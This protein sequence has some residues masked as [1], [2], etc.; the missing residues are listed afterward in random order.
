MKKIVFVGVL[1][2][3]VSVSALDKLTI[4]NRAASGEKILASKQNENMDS[5]AS[6]MNKIV[7]TVSIAT[8]RWRWPADSVLKRMNVDTIYS[9]PRI[10]TLDVDTRVSASDIVAGDSV[11][12]GTVYGATV[13]TLRVLANDVVAADSVL[14][15]TAYITDH[16][17][18]PR[19]T[20]GDVVAS[21][22]LYGLILRASTHASTPRVLTDDVVATD[23]VRAQHGEFVA[24]MYTARL[25]AAYI[26]SADTVRGVTIYGSNKVTS[27]RVTANDVAASDTV[28]GATVRGTTRV[29]TPIVLT[30]SVAV[31][32]SG[33]A[34]IYMQGEDTVTTITADEDGLSFRVNSA[35]FQNPQLRVTSSGVVASGVA[36]GNISASS[37]SFDGWSPGNYSSINM[38]EDTSFT[39]SLKIGAQNILGVAT[40]IRFGKNEAQAGMVFYFIDFEDTFAVKDSGDYWLVFPEG[41]GFN[42]YLG[43]Y[44]HKWGREGTCVSI[45]AVQSISFSSKVLQPITGIA[46]RYSPTR[47]AILFDSQYRSAN[48]KLRVNEGC[49][50]YSCSFILRN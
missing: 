41:V 28:Q 46:T 38:Y 14:G 49:R 12:G 37:I 35:P 31:V 24:S 9:R 30:D 1:V 13:S 20:T 7:D 45:P 8:L 15:A 43:T 26:S 50:I 25:A 47:G 39:C 40:A 4:P 17:S 48:N 19:I 21:D 44:D 6:K 22:T 3:V 2:A 29:S 16:V 34:N 27:P 11:I 33:A 10:D 18:T 42:E 5:I 23:S 32:A 36:A